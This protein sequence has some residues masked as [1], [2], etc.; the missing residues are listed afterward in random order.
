MLKVL[1]LVFAIVV[2]GYSYGGE[3]ASVLVNKETE[4]KSNV[5]VTDCKKSCCK[6]RCERLYNVEEDCRDSCR[7]RLFGG[8]VKKTTVR[9]VYRPVR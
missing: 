3:V 9:K 1:C 6:S 2:S 5:V 7:E 4:T 8:Y